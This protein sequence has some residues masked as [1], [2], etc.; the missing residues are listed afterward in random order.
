MCALHETVALKAMPLAS[1]GKATLYVHAP[2][3]PSAVI[4]A[5]ETSDAP[6]G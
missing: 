6:S 3:L 2:V 1:D 5:A 4:V